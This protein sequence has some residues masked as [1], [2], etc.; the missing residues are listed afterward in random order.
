MAKVILSE[1]IRAILND[2]KA[3]DQLSKAMDSQSAK[4]GSTVKYNG[5][6]YRVVVGASAGKQKSR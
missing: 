5:K 4:T 1:K 2:D 6:T 3:R